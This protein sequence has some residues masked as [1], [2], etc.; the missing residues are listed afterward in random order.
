MFRTPARLHH[1]ADDLTIPTDHVEVIRVAGMIAQL[2]ARPA[3]LERN[4]RH[5]VTYIT[6]SGARLIEYRGG[7]QK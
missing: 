4:P 7:A 2:V 6:Y 5:S 1:P 3:K